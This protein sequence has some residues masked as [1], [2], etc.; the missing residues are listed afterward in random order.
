ML[1]QEYLKTLNSAHETTP[2]TH[3]NI[4]TNIK[5]AIEQLKQDIIFSHDLIERN[6]Q[7]RVVQEKKY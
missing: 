6:L 4:R 2:Q 5:E 7:E 3:Q 1:D